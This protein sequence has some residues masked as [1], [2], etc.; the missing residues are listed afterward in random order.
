MSVE[1]VIGDEGWQLQQFT[2]NVTVEAQGH[3]NKG[4]KE[5]DIVGGA[6]SVVAEAE[7]DGLHSAA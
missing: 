2:L 3:D 1:V 7:D 5:G 4:K 6:E